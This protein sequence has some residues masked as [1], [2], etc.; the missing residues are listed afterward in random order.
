MSFND[1]NLVVGLVGGDELEVTDSTIHSTFYGY[2]ER[3]EW[4]K[5][6]MYFS[7]G[8]VIKTSHIRY[9][10]ERKVAKEDW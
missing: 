7:S 6:A 2:H 10:K 1:I 8:V 3:L 9:I 5:P 4:D